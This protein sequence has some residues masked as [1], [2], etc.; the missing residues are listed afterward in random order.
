MAD[1]MLALCLTVAGECQNGHKHCP[2]SVRHVVT[3]DKEDVSPEIVSQ[4]RTMALGNTNC[5][6]Q[7]IRSYALSLFVM[8]M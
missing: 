1:F 5:L 6:Q 4:Q 8:W 2:L 3:A 7:C